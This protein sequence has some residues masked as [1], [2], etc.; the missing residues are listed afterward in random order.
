[1][2]KNSS[3]AIEYFASSRT[4]CASVHLAHTE[5]VSTKRKQKIVTIDINLC[6]FD[7]HN[8]IPDVFQ[9]SC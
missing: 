8:Q 9:V 2:E 7:A 5:V 6:Q 3:V 1:M 4:K